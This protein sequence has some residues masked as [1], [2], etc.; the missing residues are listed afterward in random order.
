[1]T[2]W[3]A[4]WM[5]KKQDE[6]FL[7]ALIDTKAQVDEVTNRYVRVTLMQLRLQRAFEPYT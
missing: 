1:M 5:M 6:R 4:Q 3:L 2:F 7:R